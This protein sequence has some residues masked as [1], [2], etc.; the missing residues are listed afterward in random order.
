VRHLLG[1]WELVTPCQRIYQAIV[2]VVEIASGPGSYVGVTLIG[3]ARRQ[4]RPWRTPAVSAK[5][6]L[7]ANSFSRNLV[8]R[9]PKAADGEIVAKRAKAYAE[10]EPHLCDV[11][12][13]GEI[14]VRLFDSPDQGQFVFAVTHL[15]DMLQDLRKRYYALDLLP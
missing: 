6:D 2:P 1:A 11:L 4:F 12:R 13:M 3:A 14:A 7:E 8:K 15:G 9:T 10:M 5:K